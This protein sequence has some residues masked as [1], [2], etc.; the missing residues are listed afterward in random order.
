MMQIEKQRLPV[1]A[2]IERPA[3][4]S[5]DES[6]GG[7]RFHYRMVQAK[8]I[9]VELAPFLEDFRQGHRHFAVLSTDY[10]SAQQ[11]VV[12]ALACL[13]DQLYVLRI[14][15]VSDN[16]A[17]GAF[18]ELWANATDLPEGGPGRAFHDHFDLLD[19]R[20]L[21]TGDD[22]RLSQMR[23]EYDVL[24][25]DCPP[26]SAGAADRELSK[27]ACVLADTISVIVS[28][29]AMAGEDVTIK[30]HFDDFGV[31]AAGVVFRRMG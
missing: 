30:R 3:R 16:F 9:A 1:S 12:L 6:V 15:V 24:L 5:N 28:R 18:A 14:G 19:A 26:L 7:R 17:E 29:G 8:N 10:R 27:R 20:I 22:G 2:L 25:F 23:D 11:R 21:K 4:R 13:L 31:N